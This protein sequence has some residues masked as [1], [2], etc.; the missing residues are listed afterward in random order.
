MPRKPP[1]EPI[2][3][4]YNI[5]KLHKVFFLTGGV[6]TAVFVLMIWADYDRPW[7]TMQRMFFRIDARQTRELDIRRLDDAF[8]LREQRLIDCVVG[9]AGRGGQDRDAARQPP[10]AAG[11]AGGA[12]LF[13]GSSKWVSMNFAT[14][15]LT[16]MPDEYQRRMAAMAASSPLPG[17]PDA[18]PRPD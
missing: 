11:V 3:H 6:L 4:H 5:P 7:K 9:L 17:P 13:E 2:D 16:R 12:L 1:A 18:G 8:E 14:E 15:R 10:F